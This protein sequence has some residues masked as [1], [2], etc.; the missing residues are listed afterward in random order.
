MV[1]Q[2]TTELTP[3]RVLDLLDGIEAIKNETL[4]RGFGKKRQGAGTMACPV[5]GCDGLVFFQVF[6]SSGHMRAFCNKATC[7]N[8][9]E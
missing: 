3:D 6:A 4:R 7:V 8:V 2:M 5:R 9:Q 1:E